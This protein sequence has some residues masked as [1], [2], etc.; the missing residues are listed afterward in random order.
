QRIHISVSS[1]S[2][3]ISELEESVGCLLFD[4]VS[5]K[6]M[7]TPEG[8][9]LVPKARD[10]LHQADEVRRSLGERRGLRGKCRF[11]SGELSASTWLPALVARS[12]SLHPDLILEPHVD[13][14]WALEQRVEE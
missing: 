5:R 11:G 2:K 6:A 4:R 7:L 14:G 13:I 12:R 9:R 3:R 1:L 10:L 8:E